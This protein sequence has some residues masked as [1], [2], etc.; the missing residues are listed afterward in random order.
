[1]GPT[2]GTNCP[3]H[4]A[5]SCSKCHTGYYKE[6]DR[7]KMNECTCP[8][9]TSAVGLECPIN[10]TKKCVAGGCDEGFVEVFVNGSL[11]CKKA[12]CICKNGYPRYGTQCTKKQLGCAKCKRG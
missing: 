11:K 10:G 6:N 12:R 4:G 2:I 9:G 7:C 8:N 3:K 1:M 5:T